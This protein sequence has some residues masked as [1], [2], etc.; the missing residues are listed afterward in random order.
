MLL[1]SRLDSVR[2][3]G[4]YDGPL[5]VLV[6]LSAIERL[7]TEGENASFPVEVVAFADEEGLRFQNTYLG[8][9][10]LAGTFDRRC[11]DLA[12]SNGI[13]LRQ[14][15]VECGGDPEAIPDAALGQGEALAYVEVHIEQ[16]RT[17]RQ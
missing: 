11:C 14:A 17:W 12:D 8:S 10:T 9:R 15:I 6:A 1:G 3:A 16:V 2:D 4:R 13:A 5:G 7:Q